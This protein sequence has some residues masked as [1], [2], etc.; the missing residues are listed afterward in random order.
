MSHFEVGADT[1]RALDTEGYRYGIHESEY[2]GKKYRF[3]TKKKYGD[4][5]SAEIIGDFYTRSGFENIRMKNDAGNFCSICAEK[6][7]AEDFC[8]CRGKKLIAYDKTYVSHRPCT[9]I[10]NCICKKCA[11]W[12]SYAIDGI[13]C[14]SGTYNGLRIK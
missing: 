7:L 9:K 13:V 12:C 1:I 11:D 2:D 8:K 6:Q 3:V 14:A 4:P 5:G 10:E